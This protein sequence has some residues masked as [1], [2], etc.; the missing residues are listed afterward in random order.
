MGAPAGAGPTGTL[1]TARSRPGD[2]PAPAT[3]ARA[4]QRRPHLG[5][6]AA[7]SGRP[8]ADVRSPA[9]GVRA[10]CAGQRTAWW[11][12]TASGRDDPD[13][14]TAYR[15]PHSSGTTRRRAADF[16]GFAG[17]RRAAGT[18][19]YASHADAGT[20]GYAWHAGAAAEPRP[21]GARPAYRAPHAART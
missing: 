11:L 18:R 19:R 2:P 21:D 20:R 9:P 10:E 14:R 1:G 5:P 7:A 8:R 12:G 17:H 16:G 15:R 3:A 4:G 13:P 6:A